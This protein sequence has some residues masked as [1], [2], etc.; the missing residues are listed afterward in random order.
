[1]A[2]ILYVSTFGSDDPTRATLSFVAALGA[3]D[4]GHKPQVFLAGEA[5]YLMKDHIAASVRYNV[6]TWAEVACPAPVEQVA[7]QLSFRGHQL[8]TARSVTRRQFNPSLK[9]STAAPVSLLT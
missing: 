8:T 5:T 6:S 2:T 3:L 4:A 9:A 1:M 7:I